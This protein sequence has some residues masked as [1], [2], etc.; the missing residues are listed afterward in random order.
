MQLSLRYR[1][2]VFVLLFLGFQPILLQSLVM[3]SVLVVY[4]NLRFVP[5]S[6][7]PRRLVRSGMELVILDP[8]LLICI[9]LLDMVASSCTLQTSPRQRARYTL[10]PVFII[11][12]RAFDLLLASKVTGMDFQV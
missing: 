2:A 6:P 5:F 1:P 4:F 11:F 12:I 10:L 7:S 8:W 3:S 9:E